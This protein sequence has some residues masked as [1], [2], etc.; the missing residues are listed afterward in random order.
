[1]SST[2]EALQQAFQG[3][4][5]AVGDDGRPLVDSR[6][7]DPRI[8]S[9]W[10]QMLRNID[11]ELMIWSRTF[12]RAF[13]AE[14]PSFARMSQD[15]EETEE[16]P[17]EDQSDDADEFGGSDEEVSIPATAGSQGS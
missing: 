10:R 11:D 17:F 6:G 13:G 12:Q 7:V 8:C 14:P 5:E 9:E 16:D 2:L 15:Q 3:M 4:T 1:L